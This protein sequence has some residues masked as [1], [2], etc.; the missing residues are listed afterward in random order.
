MQL[1]NSSED[2]KQ[3]IRELEQ[4]QSNDLTSLKEEYNKAYKSFK[5][6]NILKNTFKDLVKSPELKTDIVN[7]AI[8]LATGVVT[9]KLLV[10]KTINP[11]KNIF[12]WLVEMVVANGVSKNTDQI[13]TVGTAI[14]KTL[15]SK[16]EKQE[17]ITN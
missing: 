16:K 3:A 11:I 6:S 13:K 14:F 12:G 1:I 8:G 4:K 17:K 15:F 5:L 10:G 2:L 7:G 9:K